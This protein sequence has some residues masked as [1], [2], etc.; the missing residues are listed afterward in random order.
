MARWGGLG[1]IEDDEERTDGPLPRRRLG[2][3]SVAN[4]R[5]RDV[6]R[7]DEDER[8]EFIRLKVFVMRFFFECWNVE[9]WLTM[10]SKVALSHCL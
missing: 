5:S 2:T 4:S 6:S 7:D 8:R 1:G 10:K 3:S 9:L